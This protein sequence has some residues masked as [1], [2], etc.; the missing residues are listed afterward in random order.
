[1]TGSVNKTGLDEKREN[2]DVLA[3]LVLKM[4]LNSNQ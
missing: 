1:M 2:A 3:I 4:R